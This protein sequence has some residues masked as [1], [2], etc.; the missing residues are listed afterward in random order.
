MEHE[1]MRRVRDYERRRYRGI[2]QRLVHEIESSIV[3]RYLDELCWPR[4]SVLDIPCGYGRF[5][6]ALHDRADTT[7]CGD[8]KLAMLQR[9][10]E[11]LGHRLPAVQLLSSA[12]PFADGSFDAVTCIRL[13][14]HLHDPEQR[15]ATLREFGRVT[16]RGAVIT[17]YTDTWAHRAIH[18]ARKLKRLTRDCL[19]D[20]EPRLADAGLRIRRQ[21][22]VLPVLH[23][24][25]VLLLERVPAKETAV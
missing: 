8:R 6:P 17:V 12:L 2:D 16:R 23:A 14:Q 4:D 19:D 11:R 22:R 9:T 10:R 24:Q 7:V 13:M 1:D 18:G 20:L 5:V 15:Q 21:S 3:E 25:T